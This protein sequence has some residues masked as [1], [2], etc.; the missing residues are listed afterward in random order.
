MRATDEWPCTSGA[1]QGP[2]ES[3]IYPADVWPLRRATEA[4]ALANVT[5]ERFWATR[6]SKDRP[7]GRWSG[8]IGGAGQNY[9]PPR[10]SMQVAVRVDPNRGDASQNSNR[11]GTP[12]N[13]RYERT[14]VVALPTNQPKNSDRTGAKRVRRKLPARRRNH[15]ILVRMPRSH[16]PRMLKHIQRRFVQI[17][18]YRDIA[19]PVT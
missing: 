3:P 13:N 9:Q 8:D 5:N 6:L 1:A 11:T 17:S 19:V 12:C 4:T 14:L 7:E 2:S 16:H 15:D 10:K 18:R